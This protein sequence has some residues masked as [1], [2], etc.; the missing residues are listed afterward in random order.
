MEA[1]TS[2]ETSVSYRS[3]T[4]RYTPEDLDLNLYLSENLK[5][6]VAND[7]SLFALRYTELMKLFTDSVQPLL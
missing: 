4:W 5:S 1:A 2:S 7:C 6:H 3:A